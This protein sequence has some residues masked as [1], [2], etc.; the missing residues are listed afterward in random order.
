MSAYNPRMTGK[1]EESIPATNAAIH[2]AAQASAAPLPVILRLKTES[3]T[4]AIPVD[5]RLKRVST[6]K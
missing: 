6:S 5:T 3:S 4:N 2:Y 1:G